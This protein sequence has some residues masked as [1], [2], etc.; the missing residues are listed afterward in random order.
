MRLFRVMSHK[1]CLAHMCLL[2]PMVLMLIIPVSAE[3]NLKEFYWVSWKTT[4]PPFVPPVAVV[5]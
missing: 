4:P 3:W 2:L 5:P 1:K